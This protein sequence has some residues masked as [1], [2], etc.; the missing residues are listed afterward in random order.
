MKDLRA[1]RGAFYIAGLIAQ[2]EH[3][4]QDFKYAISDARKI[5]RSISAFANN[6]G[7]RLLIGVKDNGVIAG[8]RNEEDIFVVEQA[9]S[10]YCRPE[11]VLR[12]TAFRCEG[13]L[14]VI[15]AEISPAGPLRPVMAQESDGR[16]RAYYR[17]ADEN[18]AAPELM[19]R[20]WIDSG[21]S[22]LDAPLI[23]TAIDHMRRRGH[24]SPHTLAASLAVTEAR[25]EE[26]ILA[27]MRMGLARMVYRDG[28][29]RVVAAN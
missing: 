13:G 11:V 23:A 17:V 12:F 26:I 19:V 29:F 15:R 21:A 27:L 1:V 14:N 22:L 16:W 10:L 7:G 8:V 24:A 9:A 2:G 3:E 18:I 5:A 25:S 4:H 28:A 6:D 20:S